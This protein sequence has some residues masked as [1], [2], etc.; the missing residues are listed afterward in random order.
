MLSPAVWLQSLGPNVPSESSDAL[1]GAS[2]AIWTTTPWT[3]PANLAVA[4][5]DALQ[6]AVVEAGEGGRGALAAGKKLVVAEGLVE[7]LSAKFNV[8]LKVIQRR[9]L[10][11]RRCAGGPAAY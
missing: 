3:I 4:V 9:A 5:N 2:F 10:A 7:P 6:Y 8:A 1:Q 11:D